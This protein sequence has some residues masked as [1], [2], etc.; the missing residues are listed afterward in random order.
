MKNPNTG[1][2]SY[3]Q[4]FNR[5]TNMAN[6]ICSFHGD[7]VEGEPAITGSGGTQTPQDLVD[8]GAAAY[9]QP[10]I[11]EVSTAPSDRDEAYPNPSH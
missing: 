3:M 11:Q 4:A 1:F 6:V 7:R 8:Y 2:V 10:I 5:Q 9:F